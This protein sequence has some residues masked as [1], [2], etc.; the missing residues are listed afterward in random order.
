[1]FQ[2]IIVKEI[3]DKSVLKSESIGK[4]LKNLVNRSHQLVFSRLMIGGLFFSSIR[5]PQMIHLIPGKVSNSAG[6]IS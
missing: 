5:C 1:M 6:S 3:N 4:N 2:Y